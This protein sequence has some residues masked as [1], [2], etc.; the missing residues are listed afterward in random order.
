MM[1]GK[2]LSSP[3][4]RATLLMAGLAVGTTA[5][6]AKPWISVPST[7][8]GEDSIVITGGG[9]PP[10]SAVTLLVTYPN[11]MKTKQVEAVN[12]AGNLQVELSLAT[13]GGYS[14]KVLDAKGKAI[15]SGRFGYFK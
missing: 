1:T 15:G 5:Y 13:P 14:V 7:P 12:A 4:L 8:T 10:N 6:A 9:L 3:W 11:G 2:R